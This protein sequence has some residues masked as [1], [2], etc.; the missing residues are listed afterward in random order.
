MSSTPTRNIA[1]THELESYIKG[2]VA[3]GHYANASEVVRA[4][5]RLLIE[6]DHAVPR[7]RGHSSAKAADR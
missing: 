4:G 6:R 3:S 7:S 1:L 2:Q 5:L